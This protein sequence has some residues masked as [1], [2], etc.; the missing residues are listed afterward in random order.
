MT[1]GYPGRG[2]PRAF[3]ISQSRPALFCY[4]CK[5]R[6]LCFCPKLLQLSTGDLTRL[7]SNWQ[8]VSFQW[9]DE[10]MATQAPS[11]QSLHRPTLEARLSVSQRARSNLRHE[12]LSKM[13]WWQPFVLI[14]DNSPCPVL[15]EDPATRTHHPAASTEPQLSLC[16]LGLGLGKL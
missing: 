10:N 2:R 3:Y 1:R 14:T 5:S 4:S 15:P 11:T 12:S 9:R 13:S 7:M 16:L 6:K 8:S